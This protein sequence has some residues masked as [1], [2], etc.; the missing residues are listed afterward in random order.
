[1]TDKRPNIVFVITD[2]Q[3]FDTIAALGYDHAVTPHL[4]RLTRRG[5]AFTHTFVTAPS[6]APSRASLFTGVY[7]HT[8]GVLKNNDP[9][10]HSWVELLAGA[11]YRCVNVGKMHTFP[12]ETSVG[13][14]ERHVVENKDRS[15]PKLPYLMDQWDKA[16]F[17]RGLVKPDRATKYRAVPDYR[18]RL[19]AF[20]WDAPD[21]LHADNF[22]GG[23]ATHW[24]DSYPGEEPFFLQ[25]GFPGPHPPY[26]PTQ[27]HLDRLADAEIPLPYDSE[28]DRAGQP[29]ALQD[30]RRDNL[31]VD[32]DAVVHLDHPTEDQVLRQRRHYL[33]N[34]SMIDEQV[35]QIVDALERRGVLEDTVLIFTSDHGDCLNDH[36]HIQK[37]SMYEPS[38]RVPAIVAG[39]GIVADQQ[40]DGL[41]SLMDLGPT[42]LE[43]AG[44]TPP[45]WMEAES[46]LPALRGESWSGRE[47]VFSEHARDMILQQT[48]LMTMVR[49]HRYKHVEF[50]D[51]ADGQ[52]FD[53]DTD[54]HEENN[55]WD[56]PDHAA[57][58][59]R[60]SRLIA[61]W[62]AE[63]ALR[64]ADRTAAFR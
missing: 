60:M 17:A 40:C 5:T 56:D 4:D 31:E 13:F 16:F 3:R 28:Q 45:S 48:A 24:L 41:A 29:Y 34:V 22:V 33:A 30:L 12:Y 8:T 14:H 23:L 18:E 49:D 19:G 50:V 47:Y 43:L 42:I 61:D 63:S 59:E 64:T 39:P 44:V 10:N 25:V 11:G 38:V 53:L 58:R 26:D 21:D 62:R 35:G 57:V 32:H 55:L 1:M 36:G 46:L 52:L 9:W 20:V 15:N 7:P 51:H 37:W 27:E 54:P 6:C 2:Q